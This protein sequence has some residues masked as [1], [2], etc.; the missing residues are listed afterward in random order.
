MK[1]IERNCAT[2]ETVEVELS[3]QEEAEAL[4]RTAELAPAEAARAVNAAFETAAAR[5]TSGYPNSERLTWPIQES[6]AL[7]WQANNGTPT[8][9]IDALAAA[10]GLSRTDYLQRTLLKVQAFRAASAAMVGVRQKAMD[11]IEAADDD[12]QAIY[13]ARDAALEALE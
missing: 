7:A 12:V 1:R 6:E 8:P 10:R 13:A 11:Q 9:Y 4:A 5:L 2:G 3:P